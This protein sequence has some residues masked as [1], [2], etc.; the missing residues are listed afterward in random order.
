M[1][2]YGS[3]QKK[4]KWQKKIMRIQFLFPQ[5]LFLFVFF[6]SSSFLYRAVCLNGE[7]PKIRREKARQVAHSATID[8][9]KT[10]TLSR[11]FLALR[12]LVLHNNQWYANR[13]SVLYTLIC[14]SIFILLIA[15]V[16]FK[17]LV[18]AESA[19]M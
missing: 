12:L 2:K 7:R 13:F 18:H 3:S 19:H 11:I 14:T 5:F 15:N 4:S 6:F 16:I 1:R 8:M 10:A 9:L 17:W